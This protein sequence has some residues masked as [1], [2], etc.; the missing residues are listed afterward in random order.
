MPVVFGAHDV[1][2]SI[3]AAGFVIVLVSMILAFLSVMSVR[4]RITLNFA[5]VPV[6]VVTPYLIGLLATTFLGISV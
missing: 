2:A 3:L 6:A 1:G 4:R 5:I